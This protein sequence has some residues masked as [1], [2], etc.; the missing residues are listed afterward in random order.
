MRASCIKSSKSNGHQDGSTILCN[1]STQVTHPPI[2]YAVSIGGE[3]VMVLANWGLAA[4][5]SKAIKEARLVEREFCFVLDAGNWEMRRRQTPVQ[6]PAA[7]TDSGQELSEAEGGDHVQKQPSALTVVLKW[8]SGG[9]TSIL[10]VSGTVNLQFQVG[11]F[12]FPWGQLSELW[13]LG[14]F[15]WWSCS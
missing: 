10:I 15:V 4:Q 8:V 5:C 11:L 2:T 1:M 3:Q 9:L 13:Q 12:P 7:P 6:R 14:P